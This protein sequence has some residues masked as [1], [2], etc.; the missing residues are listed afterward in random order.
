M[1]TFII[2]C[3]VLNIIMFYSHVCTCPHI[4][5][6]LNLA[7]LV[8]SFL[9]KFYFLGNTT[10]RTDGAHIPDSAEA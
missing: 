10:S 5:H 8:S 3:E 6:V 4:I 7:E 2:P 1:K 9:Y